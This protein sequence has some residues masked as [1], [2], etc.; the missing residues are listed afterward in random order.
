MTAAAPTPNPTT[1]VTIRVPVAMKERFDWMA[2]VMD[3]PRNYVFVEAL[4]RYLEQE[5]WQLQDILEALDE[6]AHDEGA[7][8]EDVMR[9]AWALVER[10][11]AERTETP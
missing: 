2:Q 5:E 4:Q 7:P 8:H 1:L 3:R 11:R 10:A 6:V 9:E